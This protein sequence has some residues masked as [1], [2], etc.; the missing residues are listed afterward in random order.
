MCLV[1]ATSTFDTFEVPPLA[2]AARYFVI[3]VLTGYEQHL[4]Q[5]IIDFLPMPLN[6]LGCLISA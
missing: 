5:D 2:N 4:A 6:V 3:L 1:R